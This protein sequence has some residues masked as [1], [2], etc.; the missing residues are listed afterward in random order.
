MS[1]TA[2][3]S[4]AELTGRLKA[5]A[6]RLGFEPWDRAGGRAARL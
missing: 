4:L 1:A 2:S 5:E 6:T 3:S